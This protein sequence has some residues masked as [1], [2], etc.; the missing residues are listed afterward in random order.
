MPRPRSI[1][2]GSAV[3]Q[4][5][6]T[7]TFTHAVGVSPAQTALRHETWNLVYWRESGQGLA[8]TFKE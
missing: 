4:T 8:N 3:K 7:Q 5:M 2:F 6:H 1:R